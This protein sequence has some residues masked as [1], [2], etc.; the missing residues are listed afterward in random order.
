MIRLSTLIWLALATAAGIGLFQVKY[1]VQALEGDLGQINRQIL[2]DQDA[3]HVL[4][5]EWSF[6]N[7]PGRL[8][9]LARRHLELAPFTAAQLA[10]LSDLPN[11]PAPVPPPDA[12]QPPGVPVAPGPSIA[13]LP[14]PDGAAD[15]DVAAILA[16]MRAKQ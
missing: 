15:A 9:D 16:S 1:K 3:I 11:R 8:G 14:Q 6:L 4:A 10:H 13:A 5:A 7:E 2:R 12:V